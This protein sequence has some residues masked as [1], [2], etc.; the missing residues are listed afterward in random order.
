[1][2]HYKTLGV[3][4]T[5]SPDEIKKAY[6]KL[7]SQNH[8]DKGGDT[9]KFQEI[10]TA[11]DTLSD[12]QKRQQY[13][14]PQPQFH[15]FPGG[16]QGFNGGF[17]I[18]EIFGQMF[19]HHQ[20]PHQPQPQIFRTM[21]IVNL[22]QVYTGGEEVLKLQ[23]PNGTNVV[24]I[25]IPKGIQEG[26]QVRYENVIPGA[27]LMVEFRVR[28]HL[29]YE[30]RL[31]DLYCNHSVSVLDLIVGN[32][33]EFTTISGKTFEVTVPPNTQPF[34]QLKI[35]GQG[36]PIQGTSQYGDQILLLK[37]FIPDKIDKS[38]I[39]SIKNSRLKEQGNN[40]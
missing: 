5:A 15:G 12:P 31:N 36:M 37:P 29:K 26:G 34:M 9:A 16:G 35:A 11:Y 3:A 23:T 40:D 27:G 32:T 39:D 7:A 18:N 19:R 21:V 6:R 25:D 24:K 13:D 38:I 17:D 10:Q 28:P 4:K 2:D 1:M 8:P 14:N 33:F 30:R 22:E 20:Q